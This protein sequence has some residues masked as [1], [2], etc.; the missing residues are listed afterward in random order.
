MSKQSN[1][2]SVDYR[3]YLKQVYANLNEKKVYIKTKQLMNL[4]KLS[5][6]VRV[7]TL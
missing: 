7:A 6:Y 3:V 1:Y 5:I 2:S 4:N